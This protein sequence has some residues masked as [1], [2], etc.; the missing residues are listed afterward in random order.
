MPKRIEIGKYYKLFE[1]YHNIGKKYKYFS[2][3][4]L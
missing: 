2:L 4:S 3:I 1:F